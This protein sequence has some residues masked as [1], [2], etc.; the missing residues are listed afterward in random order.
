MKQGLLYLILIPLLLINASCS[1]DETDDFP[2]VSVNLTVYPGTGIFHELGATGGSMTMA[3]GVN[4]LLIY[5]KSINEFLVFDRACPYNPNDPCEQVEVEDQGG[6]TAKDQCCE[7]VF[8]IT[9]GEKWSGPA[10]H[11]LKRYSNYYD[12]ASL[13]IWN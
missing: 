7:S 11:G 4:G 3:G 13:S 10:P 5:R 12:G 8:L 6:F 1:K 2:N 9:T